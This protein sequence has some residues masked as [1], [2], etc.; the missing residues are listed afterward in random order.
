MG[1]RGI[2]VVELDLITTMPAN[3]GSRLDVTRTRLP[4]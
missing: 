4:I 3:L 2:N 1:T